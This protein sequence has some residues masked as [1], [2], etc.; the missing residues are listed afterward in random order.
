MKVKGR[1]QRLSLNRNPVKIRNKKQLTYKIEPREK[2]K[3]HK[4]QFELE[5]R[6]QNQQ[7][8]CTQKIIQ[9]ETSKN[10]Q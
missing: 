5:N 10:N 7:S 2:R 8:V 1:A 4:R 3:N 6:N 9:T